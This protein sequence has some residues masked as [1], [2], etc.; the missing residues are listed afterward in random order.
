MLGRWLGGVIAAAGLAGCSLPVAPPGGGP[1]PV[2]FAEAPTPEQAARTFVYVVDRVVPVAEAICLERTRDV[3][4]QFQ[5]AIDERPGQAPNAFQTLDE[6]GNP[7]IA[8]NVPLLMDIRNP[9][10]L[11]FVM[12]H[13]TAHHI[14]G[15][16][17]RQ[18]TGM[19][20]GALVAGAL[21]TLG[22]GDEAAIRTAQD[23]GAELG[24]RRF[25]KEFELEADALGTEIAWR[26]GFDPLVG[27][28]FFSRLPDPGNRFLGTHPPTGQRYEAVVQT[29]QTL[30]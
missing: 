18:Q 16:I 25:S 1:P 26:A 21:A 19:M 12:G 4:C 10:E 24:A 15:H 30:R 23:M 27:A 11:A 3:P 28:Q 22:G 8:F 20:Q 5:I 17:P 29:M 6:Q 9:D 14:A 7:I 13:E 2:D